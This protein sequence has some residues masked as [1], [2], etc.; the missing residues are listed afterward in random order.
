MS[1]PAMMLPVAKRMR[2]LVI[3]GLFSFIGVMVGV[4]VVPV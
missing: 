1:S 3:A 2:G 4:R